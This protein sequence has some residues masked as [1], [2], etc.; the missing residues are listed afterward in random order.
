MGHNGNSVLLRK[1]IMTTVRESVVTVVGD[2]KIDSGPKDQQA[3]VCYQNEKA[4]YSNGNGNKFCG[5][6]SGVSLIG[7][8]DR[9]GVE[10]HKL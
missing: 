4:T 10:L 8:F 2:L 5:D 7:Q 9:V 1:K 3:L 6:D